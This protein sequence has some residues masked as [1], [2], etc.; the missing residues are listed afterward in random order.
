[1][2]MWIVRFVSMEGDVRKTIVRAVSS[3]DAIAVALTEDMGEIHKIID[4]ELQ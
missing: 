3:D 2:K 1:M 4:V